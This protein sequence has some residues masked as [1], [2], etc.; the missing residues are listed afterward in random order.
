LCCGRDEKELGCA[1][2]KLVPDHVIALS[3]GGS[4]D[5]SNIQPP[6]SRFRGLQ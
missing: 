5:I 6:L 4:N 3:R 2:L 1:G